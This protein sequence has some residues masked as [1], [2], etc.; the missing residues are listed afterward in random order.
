M[1]EEEVS[2]PPGDT[3]ESIRVHIFMIP[4]VRS[5]ITQNLLGL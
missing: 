3:Q 2:S 5:K 4:N 1:L